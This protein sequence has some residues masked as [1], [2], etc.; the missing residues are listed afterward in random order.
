MP[1]ESAIGKPW[2]ERYRPKSLQEVSHQSEVV[3]TLQNAVE[4]GRLPHLLFYG[5]PGSGKVCVWNCDVNI[6][7]AGSI[8]PTYSY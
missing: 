3:A 2:I 5:P 8:V 6:A 4:T 1:T 7:N